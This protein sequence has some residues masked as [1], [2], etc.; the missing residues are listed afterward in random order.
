MDQDKQILEIESSI[1]FNCHTK[2]VIAIHPSE[3]Y[4]LY[5]IGSLIVVKSVDGSKDKYLRGHS[6][7]VNFLTVSKR[8]NLIASGEAFEPQSEDSAALIVWDFSSLAV[9]Y[10]VRFHRQMIQ[11]LSFNS[12]ET[13][14]GSVGGARDGNQLVIW[15]MEQGKSEAFVPATD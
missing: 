8:G 4:M 14:L 7:R 6:G 13:F 10:R 9:M 11:A 5:T 2:N 3:M 15:N 12:D 1:G